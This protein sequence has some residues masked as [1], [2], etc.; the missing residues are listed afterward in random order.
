MNCFVCNSED[1]KIINARAVTMLHCNT[2]SAEWQQNPEHFVYT[3]DYYKKIWG[4]SEETDAFVKKSKYMM[5]KKIIS[6]IKQCNPKTILDVGCGLGYLLSFLKDYDAEGVEISA[7]AREIAEKR[8]GKK[9]YSSL[10]EIKKKYD[11]IIFYDS[12]EHI[13]DHEQL[14]RNIT[15]LLNEGGKG[16]VIM[17]ASDSWIKKIMG[18]HWIEYKKDHVL[19]YSQKAFRLQLKN[20]GFKQLFMHSIWKTVTLYYLLS[21]LSFFHAG[22]LKNVRRI[23]PKNVLNISISLPIGQ[24]LAVFE[25]M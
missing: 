4:Y 1:N 9:V 20:H 21:Y 25:K 6:I 5:S 13:A 18:R 24:M 10:K 12:F 23:L 2:C 22:F 19:F 7:F 17:P 16:I 11:I 15:Q 8:T 3:E 14:F